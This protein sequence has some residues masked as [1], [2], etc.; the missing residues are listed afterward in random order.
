VAQVQGGAI[1]V[2][3]AISVAVWA[4]VVKE[5]GITAD[6]GRRQRSGA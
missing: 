4:R 2:I 3:G 6:R 1:R 5:A